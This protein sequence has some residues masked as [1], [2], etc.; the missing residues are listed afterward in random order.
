M[1]T[2]RPLLLR[3]LSSTD[4]WCC[5]LA[6]AAMLVAQLRRLLE[7]QHLGVRH[8]LGLQLVHH[9]LLLAQQEALGVAHIAGVVLGEMKPT[10]GPVQRR[11]WYSRQGRERLL[12]TVSSQVRRRNTFCRA[13]SSPSPP[14]RCRAPVTA[15]HRAAVVGHAALRG[16]W[17]GARRRGCR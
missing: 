10:Q 7:L 15:V 3:L 4:C 13:G 11:I 16:G 1:S 17:P 6:S 14:R 8:H 12:K 9:R 2:S 5:T